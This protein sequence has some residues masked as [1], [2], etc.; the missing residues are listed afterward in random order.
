[1]A[2]AAFA[3]FDKD[4]DGHLSLRE[5]KESVV[6]IF[7][8]RKNMAQSLKDTDSIVGSLEF[9]IGVAAHFVMGAIYLLV[10]GVDILKGFSTFSATVLALTFVFGQSVRALY[11]SMLFL[12]IVHPID[13]GDTVEIEGLLYTVKQLR[14]MSTC[15]VRTSGERNYYP[16][17]RLITLPIINLTRSERRCETA[18]F[19][20]D[21][22]AGAEAA[23]SAVFAALEAHYALR[24]ADFAAAPTVNFA[25]LNDP[26]KAQISVSWQYSFAGDDLGRMSRARTALLSCVQAAMHAVHEA[27]GFRVPG[28][29][30]WASAAR[31]AAGALAPYYE[32]GMAGSRGGAG[33]AGQRSTAAA[34]A[35]ALMPAALTAAAPGAAADAPPLPAPIDLPPW[36]YTIIREPPRRQRSGGGGRRGPD[37]G[38]GAGGDDW[39]PG[40]SGGAGG[41]GGGAGG[42]GRDGNS[43]Q[44]ADL[45]VAAMATAG[46]V[47]QQDVVMRVLQGAG[48]A[49]VP[50]MDLMGAMGGGA[51]PLGL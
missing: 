15:L 3:F 42:D 26:F 33:A 25:A 44:P 47:A 46:T 51:R 37:S 45:A 1:M 14:L 23:R 48:G 18:R 32:A 41:G 24:S 38:G 21:A 19:C 29:S 39:G 5:M 16:N 40:G 7:K 22:G 2:N 31:C 30:G 43:G 35:G 9:G 6:A 36:S 13:V 10:W 4:N 34:G 50:G 28:E 11:E 49:P 17:T 12:F 8:E 27:G 20:V